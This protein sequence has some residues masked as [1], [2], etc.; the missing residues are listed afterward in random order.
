MAGEIIDEGSLEDGNLTEGTEPA[1][2]DAPAPAPTPA[3]APDK[4]G[5]FKGKSAEEIAEAYH[6]LE[7]VSGRLGAELG[8]LRKLTDSY[9]R[10]S[11]EQKT[12]P[13]PKQEPNTEPDD[14]EF[15]IDP[16]KAI[17]RAIE[18]D[19]IIKELRAARAE[20]KQERAARQL[21]EAHPD[22]QEIVADP[23]FQK[24]VEASPIR[25]SLFV[26]AHTQHDFTAADELLGTFK[27]IRGT[28]APAPA[29]ATDD[30]VVEA[31]KRAASAPTG[32]T[33]SESA[34]KLKVYSRRKIMDLMINNPAEYAARNDEFLAAYADG[35]VV[36]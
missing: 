24:W 9:I 31:Q 15:F 3:P 6:E 13:A 22:A 36:P 11:L 34:P 20:T 27:S 4:L 10:S 7:K 2:A 18:D 12:I 32:T 19:E 30:S 16:R 26:Q 23:E 1:V 5:K 25:R 14:A 29:P 17:K 33:A 8:D 21:K 35:R 28:K